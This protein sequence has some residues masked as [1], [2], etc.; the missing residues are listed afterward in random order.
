MSHPVTLMNLKSK[1]FECFSN[2]FDSLLTSPSLPVLVPFSN[3]VGNGLIYEYFG[4]FSSS[5][6]YVSSAAAS[7]FFVFFFFYFY[8]LLF[9]FFFFY[10]FLF[11]LLLTSLFLPLF[12]LI[13][14]DILNIQKLVHTGPNMLLCF[15]L[16]NTIVG[17]HTYNFFVDHYFVVVWK[18]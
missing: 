6:E 1:C 5:Y 13:L 3:P 8:F 4:R 11:F 17:P 9:V 7:F 14:F 15:D 2:L 18:A 10:F 12:L 16:N